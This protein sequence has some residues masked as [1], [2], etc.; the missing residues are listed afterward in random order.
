MCNE[1]RKSGREKRNEATWPDLTPS[2][3]SAR[4]VR[5]IFN[6]A[7]PHHGHLTDHHLPGK[8]KVEIEAVVVVTVEASEEEDIDPETGSS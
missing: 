6:N 4:P 7:I 8:S 2:G 1:L 3:K 5:A